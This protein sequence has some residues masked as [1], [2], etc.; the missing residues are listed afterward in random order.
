MLAVGV[1][2]RADFFKEFGVLKADI[3]VRSYEDL[4]GVTPFNFPMTEIQAC[5]GYHL[6][7]RVT[8]LN[9]KR[10]QR[11]FLHASY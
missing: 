10:N 4:R 5:T 6:L 7:D 9:F 1:W 11:A 2:R 3:N 8:K